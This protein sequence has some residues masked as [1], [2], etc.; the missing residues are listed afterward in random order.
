MYKY[1]ARIVLKR[2]FRWIFL[3]KIIVFSKTRKKAVEILSGFVD[4]MIGFGPKL[5]SDFF[6]EYGSK[7]I[8]VKN[9]DSLFEG[10]TY[11]C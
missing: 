8:M 7:N 10:T 2:C 4:I 3:S 1:S 6:P 9:F 11:H 5:F